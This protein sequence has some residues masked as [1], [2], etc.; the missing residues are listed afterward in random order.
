MNKEKT[1]NLRTNKMK[2]GLKKLV[3]KKNQTFN[4][5]EQF[6]FSIQPLETAQGTNYKFGFTNFSQSMT[7]DDANKV[8]D[9]YFTN[10]LNTIV[11]TIENNPCKEKAVCNEEFINKLENI[12]LDNLLYEVEDSLDCGDE[13]LEYYNINGFDFYIKIRPAFPMALDYKI[14]ENESGEE[15]VYIFKSKITSP[16]SSIEKIKD[17]IYIEFFIPTAFDTD[18]KIEQAQ[19]ELNEMTKQGD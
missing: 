19:K 15:F 3:K 9:N 16:L 1:L 8:D 12:K 5:P 17:Y 10:L 11:E 6:E 7:I 18:K 13:K 4:N 2:Q 14:A